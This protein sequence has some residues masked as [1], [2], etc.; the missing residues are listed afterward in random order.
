VSRSRL[1]S[2]ALAGLALSIAPLSAESQTRSLAGAG[3]PP[4]EKPPELPVRSMIETLEERWQQACDQLAKRE[5]ISLDQAIRTGLLNNPVLSKTY[6]DIQAAQWRAIAVRREWYP[7]LTANNPVT[8]PW[9]LSTEVSNGNQAAGNAPSTYTSTEKFYTSPRLR[10]EWSFLDPTRTPRL[11]SDLALVNAQQL[12]FDV[13]A[14]NL[15]LDIQEAYYRLQEAR[16]LREDYTRIYQ[17]TRAQIKKAQRLRRAGSGSKG[18]ID[19]LR[20]QLLQQLT[21]LTQIY[22]QE[23]I[24]ANQLA[25]TLSLNP[26]TLLLPSERLLPVQRWRTPLQPTIDEA[27]ALR[28]EIK[29]NLASADSFGWLSRAR[30][31]LY[32]PAV[33]LLGQSQMTTTSSSSLNTGPETTWN[34]N[35]SAQ[36]ANALGLGFNWLMFDGGRRSA[37]ASVLNQQALASRSQADVTRLLVTLQVQN[38]YATFSSNEMVIDMARVQLVIARATVDYTARNY[39][40]S[41]IDATTFIQNIQNYLNAARNYK[42]SVKDF[43]IAVASLYRYSARWPANTQVELQDRLQPARKQART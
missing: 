1:F 39:N 25:Y 8:P 33:G 10:L 14:R 4:L 31:S 23:L 41:T 36:L 34:Q 15:I 32:L 35:N 5:L 29:A 16:E 37:D 28:E 43:N 40:G 22:E 26:G 7:S 19:Q 20:A 27:L 9:A 18:D 17:L 38:S 3:S 24:A 13:S 12:L 42:A 6:A 2:V 11:K 30:L 21:Q